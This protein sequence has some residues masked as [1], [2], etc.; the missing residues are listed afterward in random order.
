[1]PHSRALTLIRFGWVPKTNLDRPGAEATRSL[2]GI[3]YQALSIGSKILLLGVV[4][5]A[6]EKQMKTFVLALL[7]VGFAQTGVA[8]EFGSHW[9]DGKAELD[10]YRITVNRYGQARTGHAVAIYVTEPFSESKRVK[11][12]RQREGDTFNALKLNLV[13]DFQTGIYDYNTMLSVFVRSDDFSPSKVSFSSAEW[14]GHVYE[15]LLFYP[16]R[17]EGELFSYF[18]NESESI[19]LGHPENGVSEDALFILLRGLRGEALAAGETLTVPF[20][21]SPYV[22]RLTHKRLAWTQAEIKR[23]S[24]NEQTTVPAGRFETMVYDVSIADDGREGTFYVETAYPHRIVRWNL[25]PDTSAEMTGSMRVP[26]WS[27]NGN[28]HERYLK[29]LGLE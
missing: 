8:D 1:M 25:S 3:T 7:L 22:T 14:C 27:L 13:R 6:G 23:R 24:E 26:Y 11:A 9:F 17:V 2:R 28:A 21:P 18:E 5:E 16:G 4:P 20:L 10:A 15:E 29:E 12:D 19:D